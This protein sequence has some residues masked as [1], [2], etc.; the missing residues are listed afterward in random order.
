MK[1]KY[2]LIGF[3]AVMAGMIIFAI[4]FRAEFIALLNQPALYIHARFVHIAAVTLFLSN[5]V[6]GMLWEKRSLASGSAEVILQTYRTV[7]WIDARL[8]SPLIILS[9]VSGLSLS[10]MM[11]DLWQI[12]WLSAGF[13]LFILSGVFWVVG[14]IP[15]QYKVKKLMAALDPAAKELPVELVRLLKLRWWISLGGVAP[16]VVVFVLMVYQPDIS[17]LASLFR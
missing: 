13:V 5:A 15:T 1:T 16:L 8:S 4:F 10:F 12:G 3:L 6:L 9:V 7:A 11:G 2:I 17:A 14:D